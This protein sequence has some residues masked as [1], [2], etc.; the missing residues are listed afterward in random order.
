[1]FSNIS[2]TKKILSIILVIIIIFALNALV[3]PP[4]FLG[5]LR[6]FIFGSDT[7]VVETLPPTPTTSVVANTNTAPPNAVF[8]SQPSLTRDDVNLLIEQA[9]ARKALTIQG[10]QGIAGPAGP[11]GTSGSSGGSS[12]IDTSS[13]VSRELFDGQVDRIFDSIEDNNA[14]GLVALNSLDFAQFEDQLDLDASTDILIDGAKV[15]SITNTGT[16]NSLLVNDESSDASPFVIDN[17]GNVGIGITT[18]LALL[19][20]SGP[21]LELVENGDFD[22]D[23]SGWTLAA[24]WAYDDD[25]VVHTTLN[26]G[27]MEQDIGA[28]AG[29]IYLLT[30]SISGMTQG[31]ICWSIGGEGD[32]TDEG[33][34]IQTTYIIATDT[35]NLIFDPTCDGDEPTGAFDGTISD[36]SVVEVFPGDTNLVTNGTFTGNATGWTLEAGWAYDTNNVTYTP[37]E[38]DTSVYQNLDIN[39]GS[40]YRVSFD[41]NGGTAGDLCYYIDDNERGH[42]GNFSGTVSELFTSNDSE[43][44]LYFYDCDGLGGS[45]DGTIDNVIV[46][47]ITTPKTL[48]VSDGGLEGLFVDGLGAVSVVGEFSVDGKIIFD[49]NIPKVNG[50]ELYMN[51]GN[52]FFGEKQ[53]NSFYERRVE[54]VSTDPADYDTY[55]E[56]GTFEFDE[57]QGVLTVELTFC[58]SGYGQT[59]KHLIPLSYNND[60]LNLYDDALAVVDNVWIVAGPAIE[61]P[62]NT[63]FLGLGDWELQYKVINSSVSLR[64]VIR[65]SD[66]T[67]SLVTA[68]IKMLHSDNFV[69][70][71]YTEEVGVGVD[72]TVYERLPSIISAISGR[73]LIQNTLNVMGNVG[74]GMT[75]PSVALDVT[76]NIEYTGTITDVSDERL[77]ENI[78]DFGSGLEIVNN[79][80]VK[81]FNMIGSDKIE[82]GFIA[83]NVK[84]IWPEGVSVIDPE[85]GYMGVS[86]VSFVPILTKAVQE[87]SQII[88]SLKDDL[89]AWFAD[90]GNGIGVMYADVFDAKEKIC[91]DGE[92]LTAHDVRALLDLVEDESDDEETAPAPQEETPVEETIDTEPEE[93]TP[94]EVIPVSEPAPEENPE[95]TE[96][97]VEEPSGI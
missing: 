79:I 59:S 18:P 92:C 60:Y 2:F 64:F 86:Y 21:D 80:G 24:G 94:G 66:T 30:F 44:I 50:S 17:V 81:S 52:L 20:V 22:G 25:N 28:E 57:L 76:G 10:P 48:I 95:N 49:T 19:D 53:L 54:D 32:G 43:H 15:L 37:P 73:T 56:I 46:E 6:G 8:S 91:V 23:A 84:D 78:L 5:A 40:T 11:K 16:G 14:D 70:A 12:N 35:S 65:G 38:D 13:F 75:G 83:Q 55:Y 90:V 87:L 72:A 26:T 29:K 69:G 33:A 36:V 31:E 27:T 51:N 77:K 74:I 45:Y 9:L 93:T 3:S 63:A 41:M 58:C 42:D 47:E 1:M 7:P 4:G 97:V 34:G 96:P 89:I 39:Q 61:T 82:T 71:R 67:D 68:Y 88:T 62:R 85:N